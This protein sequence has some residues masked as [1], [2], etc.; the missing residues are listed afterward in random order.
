V[1]D[2]MRE[3]EE[4]DGDAPAAV[5]SG[6]VVRRGHRCSSVVVDGLPTL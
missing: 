3:I 5:V 6:G 2:R 1:V 4:A